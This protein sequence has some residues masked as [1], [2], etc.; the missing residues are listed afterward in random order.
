MTK[1]NEGNSLKRLAEHGQSPWFDFIRRDFTANGS[2]KKMVEEDGLMGVTSNPAIF[3]KAIGHGAEYESE[4]RSLLAKHNLSAGE[5]YEH[6]AIEDI[7]DACAVLKPVF[8]K[9]KKRDGYVSLE[10]SPYIAY[11]QA[12]TIADARRLWKEVNRENLMIKIPATAE[13]TR[14]VKD[15]IADGINVNVTLL[16]SLN[17][18][19]A[20]LESYIQGLEAR[21]QKGQSIDHLASVASFFVSRIDSK[22][23]AEID[24]RIAENAPEAAELKKLRGKVAIANA[25][26]AYQH[27]LEVSKS[28]RWKAL[29]AKG[30]QPQRL[31]WASTGTKDKAYSDVLYVEELIGADTVNT[32][33]PATFD[34]FRDHGKLRGSLL[35]D[36]EGARKVLAEAERLNLNLQKVT[37][38]LVIEGCASFC[39]AFD[40]LLGAVEARREAVLSDR[41][42][43]LSLSLPD[44]LSP[45]VVAA[46]KKWS[47]GGG[48]RRIWAHDAS[49]W[50]N[51]P[52]S[53][54]LGWLNAPQDGLAQCDAYEKFAKEVK[55]RGYSDILLLGMGGSSL[56]PEVLEKTFGRVSGAAQLHVLDSTDPQ[57]IAH[58]AKQVDLKKT[59]F[60]V[61]SKSGSTLEPNI[62]FAYFWEQ[63]KAA[64]GQDPGEHFV[65]VT[66]PGSAFEKKAKDHKFGHIFHGNPEIGGRYSVL[67][68]FG[69]VPAAAAG[70]D[71]RAFLE[72]VMLM[73]SSCDGSVPPA[74]NPGARLGLALGVAAKTFG[75]DKVTLC[76][77]EGVK[78]L[79]AWAEQ[80]IAE[81]TGKIGTGLIPIDGETLGEPSVYGNDRVF[82]E[83]RLGNEPSNS[84]LKALRDAGHP[85]L[86]LQ[87]HTKEQ[88]GQAFFVLEF[89]IAVAGSVLGIDPFDQPDVEFSKVETRKLTEAY[90]KTG[91]LPQ[92]APFATDGTLEFYA[93]DKNA[94]ALG[95][96]DAVSILKAHFGRVK[97]SDY[98]GLLAYIEQNASH[99]GWEQDLRL[100]LRDALHVATAAQFGPRFLHST[101]QAYKGGPDSGV[102]LQITADDAADL[103]VP[104][105]SYSFGVVK[106][107]QARGDFDVLASR[108]RRAL[109][110]HVKGSLEDGLKRLTAAVKDALKGIK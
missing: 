18:Y 30:A 110:V 10:V 53:K 24:R 21:V 16:F 63:A 35:E 42:A 57:Q 87:L 88:I 79:G 102:F 81:S 62:L 66:D 107:A 72:S 82:V 1:N 84:R 48:V 41:L 7:R 4:V 67:S 60:I 61:S 29:E 49:V 5:L 31:L 20:V 75:R 36:I 27:Y 43:E 92:E 90:E 52:E 96:G 91:H 108:G 40:A 68:A 99:I 25:K 71:V 55:S 103:K 13:G 19:K 2:L 76:A 58:F 80:L 98:I 59:L 95:K 17:A 32:I 105:A 22:I 12:A 3:E 6:I 86:S 78:A 44:E 56:G 15:A 8:D 47:E 46:E 97:K 51:G 74:M 85:V 9:T 23:D 65:A 38:T 89:A 77:S 50:T 106:A 93:D 94:Q 83:V 64:L 101:G 11:D 33:P 34:A 14:A 104:G 39:V 73:V 28:A 26:L 54:W 70:Y 45:A 109:R 69:L 100:A 37:E